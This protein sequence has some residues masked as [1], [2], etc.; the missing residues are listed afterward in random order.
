MR[1]VWDGCRNEKG[2]LVFSWI[3]HRLCSSL[4]PLPLVALVGNPNWIPRLLTLR[5]ARQENA[6]E[7]P[8]VKCSQDRPPYFFAALPMHSCLFW[9]LQLLRTDACRGAE[10]RASN[11]VL[12]WRPWHFSSRLTAPQ[13]GIFRASNDCEV[14]SQ[15]MCGPEW[16]ELWAV[17]NVQPEPPVSAL[18]IIRNK[19]HVKWLFDWN[20]V[21]FL[22][23]MAGSWGCGNVLAVWALQKKSLKGTWRLVAESTK[24]SMWI[25]LFF[26]E[27]CYI[28]GNGCM[29]VKASSN[30]MQSRWRYFAL[31]WSA[32][33]RHAAMY[34]FRISPGVENMQDSGVVLYWLTGRMLIHI[35]WTMVCG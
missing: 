6:L 27:K 22:P 25:P 32:K 34:R 3:P 28:L 10:E 31:K 21:I 26:S 16:A 8:K 30:Q 33:E 14:H 15:P 29:L 9:L 5:R 2:L 4:L 1:L 12:R 20:C 24:Q 13:I 23:E 7:H 19:H 18:G 35:L 11:A 17:Y